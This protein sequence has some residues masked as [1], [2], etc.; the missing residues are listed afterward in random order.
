MQFSVCSR[1]CCL[2]DI[3]F[4][5]PFAYQHVTSLAKSMRNVRLK[6]LGFAQWNAPVSLLNVHQH[7]IV[8]S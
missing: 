3:R 7:V 6:T 4:V 2:S 5:P 8:G 1:V